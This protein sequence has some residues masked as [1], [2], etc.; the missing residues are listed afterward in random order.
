ME[1]LQ[2]WV[3]LLHL[4]MLAIGT[5]GQVFSMNCPPLQDSQLGNTSMPSTEGLLAETL[6]AE[7]GNAEREPVQILGSNPVCLVQGTMRDTYQAISIVVRYLSNGVEMVLQAEYMC[8]DME[9]GFGGSG[10][11]LTHEVMATLNTTV[12]T[13]CSLC[14]P[15]AVGGSPI[16][17]CICKLVIHSTGRANFLENL[18][19]IGCGLLYKQ[20]LEGA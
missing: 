4:S 1:N 7:S 12:L 17:H 14:A 11:S 9:W 19:S 18:F 13:N 3:T 20:N 2:F 15:P 6:K 10:V 8:N 16:E 5:Q